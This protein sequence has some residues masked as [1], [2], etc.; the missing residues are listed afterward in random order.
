M[1]I[2]KVLKVAGLLVVSGL[3]YSGIRYG[4]AAWD[5][6]QAG[7]LDSVEMRKYQGTSM[8]NLKALHTALMLYH[9]S[10]GQFPSG[11]GWMDAIKT[12]LR[13]NDLAADE[14]VKKYKNPLIGDKANQYGYAFNDACGA[15]YIEDIKE[16]EKTLLVFDSK[17]TGWN[18][19]G[20]PSKLSPQPER[21]G[22]NLGITVSGKILR[23]G[24]PVEAEKGDKDK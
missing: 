12:R 17:E 11:A 18:A 19:H 4:P 23:S 21:Q 10:E 6:Y 22:G 14:A 24:K 9:D 20:D 7:F 2:G 13:T 15:K 1:K 8:E 5:L 3:V 16:P